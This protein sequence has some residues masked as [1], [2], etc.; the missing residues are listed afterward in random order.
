DATQSRMPMSALPRLRLITG[1][2]LLVS[3]RTE[4]PP[5]HV[6]RD[7][8]GVVIIENVPGMRPANRISLDS[9]PILS[10]G[11]HEE[12]TTLQF[13][14]MVGLTRLSNGSI[15]VADGSSRTLR[16]FEHDGDLLAIAGGSG[17][18]PGRF[19]EL[20]S[21]WRDEHDSVFVYDQ[22]LGRLSAFDSAGRYARSWSLGTSGRRPILLGALGPDRLLGYW[23]MPFDH[24]VQRTGEVRDSVYLVML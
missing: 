4:A 19:R 8:A 10:I 15:V 21:V 16:Y 17:E 2:F 6:V 11:G 20:S 5:V 1:A 22:Y 24:R 9:V 13:Y 18:G 3:C 23:R 12:D 14:G 7:S